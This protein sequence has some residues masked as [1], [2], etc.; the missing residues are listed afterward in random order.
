MLLSSHSC[1]HPL[2]LPP[3][4][5]LASCA[6]YKKARRQ[7]PPASYGVCIT[8]FMFRV[9]FHTYIISATLHSIVTSYRQHGVTTTTCV[10]NLLYYSVPEF[11]Y[12]DKKEILKI[13]DVLQE[14]RADISLY[15]RHL[16]C[17]TL[18]VFK[19]FFEL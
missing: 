4:G 1:H 11:K 12:L 5:L 8:N 13:A 14:V 2:L 18:T 16:F 9:V 19:V 7:W 17:F 10:R 6:D 3:L 15:K